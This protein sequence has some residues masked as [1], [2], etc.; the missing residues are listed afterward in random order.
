[1]GSEFIQNENVLSP[2][3][4]KD[5][6]AT[7]SLVLSIQILGVTLEHA[8]RLIWGS[9]ESFQDI[10]PEKRIWSMKSAVPGRTGM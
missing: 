3:L 8:L 4:G 10:L 9:S 2:G 5:T 1:V 7:D 6:T